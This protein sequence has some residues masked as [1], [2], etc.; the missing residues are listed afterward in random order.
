MEDSPTGRLSLSQLRTALEFCVSVQ[1]TFISAFPG[2]LRAQEGGWTELGILRGPG[3]SMGLLGP[4]KGTVAGDHE[5]SGFRA[6]AS[7]SEKLL[8]H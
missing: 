3:G 1:L 4:L 5:H 2:P 8:R 6:A 7:L